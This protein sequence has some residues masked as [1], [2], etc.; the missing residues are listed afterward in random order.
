M[1]IVYTY[2]PPLANGPNHT[3]P[4]SSFPS[5]WLAVHTCQCVCVCKGGRGLCLISS[6]LFNFF[7]SKHILRMVSVF[8]LVCTYSRSKCSKLFVFP[9]SR[10]SVYMMHWRQL[11]KT[12]R[13]RGQCYIKLSSVQDSATQTCPLSRT[14]LHKTALCSGQRCEDSQ[15]TS[16]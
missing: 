14:T 6:Q 5:F 13:C 15:T 4:G 1:Y 10:E 12:L 9:E 2:L 7:L 16:L 8:C 11:N 3:F